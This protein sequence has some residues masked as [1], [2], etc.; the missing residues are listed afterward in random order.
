MSDAAA[1]PRTTVSLKGRIAAAVAAVV[2]VGGAV[3]LAAALAYGRHA[4]REAYDRLLVGAAS[5]IAE[6]ITIRDGEPV[7]DLPVSAFELLALAG[8]DRIDYRVTDKAGITLTGSPN[9]PRP[10]TAR[11]VDFY[12]GSFG[13]ESA[14]Y[15][16]VTRRFAERGYSGPVEIV[17]GHTLLARRELA[18][19]IARNALAVLGAAGIAIALFASLAVASALTPLT[20]IGDTLARRDP[21]DLTPLVEPAPREIAALRDALNAFMRRLERQLGANRDLISDAAHQLRTPLAAIRVQLD[22]AAE[23]DDPARQAALIAR[24]QDRA[25]TLSRLLD[26]LLSQGMVVHR[27]DAVPKER[28]DL[29]D[30]ALE[31]FEQ[32]DAVVIPGGR[33]V[34]LDLPENEVPIAGDLLSLAEAGKNLLGNALRHGAEPVALGVGVADGAARLWVRDAG[35]GPDPETLARMGDR[36]TRDSASAGAG[37]LGLA[38]ANAVAV[39]HGGRLA[40][41]RTG[42]GFEIALVLPLERPE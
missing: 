23:E 5:D 28:L 30:V 33:P 38:I 15:V 31:V 19:D 13:G 21:T 36:F 10:E 24:V 3:V 9:A 17:V 12:N 40:P 41:S 37:G 32:T 14:R 16:A 8:R 6:S 26:Q 34:R 11:D 4:A 22:A 25:R 39:N 29:R 2:L 18:H 35:P 7:V 27:G 42:T 20:R 1:T